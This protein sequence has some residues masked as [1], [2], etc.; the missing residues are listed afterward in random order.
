MNNFF[1][2]ARLFKALRMRDI[3]AADTIKVGSGFPMELVTIRAAATKQKNWGK[4]SLMTIKSNK[5]MIDDEDVL[6]MTWV[7]NNTVQFMSTVHTVDEMKKMIF[8]DA[9]RRNEVP[10]SVI[11]DEKLPFPAPIVEYNQHMGESNGNAQQRA[12]YSSHRPDSRYWW[13]LFIFLLDAVV[14]NAFKLWGRLYSDS[15]LT[16]SEFQHEIIE[17]LLIGG[18][19]K[20]SSGL[21]ILNSQEEDEQLACE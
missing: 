13:P 4:M 8:K 14:L 20:L 15:K 17:A 11:W 12:Y 16:H 2:N 1:T 19:R 18:T 21:S 10:K 5:K 7:N 9:K 3:G 6:C